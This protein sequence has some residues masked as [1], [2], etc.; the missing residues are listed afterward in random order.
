MVSSSSETDPNGEEVV[1]VVGR[2]TR[3]QGFMGAKQRLYTVV[4]TDRR[5]LFA[6]FTRERQKQLSKAADAQAQFEGKGFLGRAAAQMHARD[7]ITES[8]AAMTPDEVLGESPSNFA[9]DRSEIV[10]VKFKTGHGETAEDYVVIKTAEETIKLQ[11]VQ[12]AHRP[13]FAALKLT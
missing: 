8:Y 4:V 9:I 1:G 13:Q 2:F 12:R 3:V 7:G 6:E 5:V 10:K 11:G